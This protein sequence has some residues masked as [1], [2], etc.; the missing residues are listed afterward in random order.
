MN[1]R[2]ARIGQVLKAQGYRLTPARQQILESLVLCRGHVSADEL[3]A[4]VHR[5]APGI[6]RMTVY[7]TLDLLHQLGLVRPV[8]QGGAAAHYVLL[9]EGHH[10]HLICSICDRVVEFEECVLEEI[11]RTIGRHFD[12]QIQ[13]HLLEVYGRCADCRA[14]RRL[15]SL[16]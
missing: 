10:H 7:R 8:Y 14:D 12:F 5:Q 6:G 11:E 3:V 13:G 15:E 16:S 2:A 1:E 9:E 4:I